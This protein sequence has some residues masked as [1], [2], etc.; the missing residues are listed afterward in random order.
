MDKF[1]KRF[2]LYAIR[3]TIDNTIET[4]KLKDRDP[5]KYYDSYTEASL[6]LRRYCEEYK[7]M[8]SLYE[9]VTFKCNFVEDETHE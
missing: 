6:T 3:Y 7:H 9:I 1:K 5:T 2:K 8:L 4:L